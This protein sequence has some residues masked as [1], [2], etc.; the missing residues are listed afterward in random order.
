MN[1]VTFLVDGF[2]LYHSAVAATRYGSTKWLDLVSLCKSYLYI[3]RQIRGER[4]T[5]KEVHYFTALPL[6]RDMGK[7][8][9]HKCYIKCLEHT[10]VTVHVSRFRKKT[11]FCKKCSQEFTAYE[12]KESDVALGV[13]LYELCHK[14][15][16]DTAFLVTGDTDLLPAVKT[17][18]NV[19]PTKTIL[20][21]FPY[22]RMNRELENIAPMSNRGRTASYPAAPSQIPACGFPAQGSSVLFASYKSST[23]T[24]TR[25][26]GA[27][28]F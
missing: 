12:E 1:R 26:S 11:V 27:E 4:A 22:R 24:S 15:E 7:I 5:M 19:F 13:K 18:M 2:N 17:C 6:H 21:L 28:G 9:R 16:F 23:I 14:D 3:A 25:Q 10:G 20:F 8:N